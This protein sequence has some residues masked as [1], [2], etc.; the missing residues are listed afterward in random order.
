MISSTSGT[1][2]DLFRNCFSKS[3]AALIS[4]YLA[5]S[6]FIL[7]VDCNS[8]RTLNESNVPKEHING[9]EYL[10]NYYGTLE[11]QEMNSNNNYL[12]KD[13]REQNKR[14][15][16]TLDRNGSTNETGKTLDNYNSTL[17]PSIT[18][19][20]LD[21]FK[22]EYSFD[23]YQCLSE[24]KTLREYLQRISL[25]FY[26][27][28]KINKL[29]SEEL[30]H[31][32]NGL[33][34]EH[35]ET[36]SKTLK[37]NIDTGS[38]VFDENL[39]IIIYPGVFLN[40][41]HRTNTAWIE[42]LSEIAD[43][44]L[45]S[46]DLAQIIGEY[47]DDPIS[48]C[49]CT[50]VFEAQLNLGLSKSSLTNCIEKTHEIALALK[51]NPNA[52]F[53]LTQTA[54]NRP[55][56]K[57]IIPKSMGRKKNVSSWKES[58][59]EGREFSIDDMFDD[60]K[61]KLALTYNN[62]SEIIRQLNRELYRGHKTQDSSLEYTQIGGNIS[63]FDSRN[64][65]GK[66]CVYI[67]Y[68]QGN[69]G[70]C[71]AFVVSASIS[72]SNCI[73]KSELP[74]PLSPQQIIDC[75]TNYGNL[76][77]EGGFYS[78]GWS[79]LLEQNVPKNLICSWEEYPYIDAKGTCRGGICDGCLTITKYNVFTGLA[80]NGDDGWDFVTTI[81][82]KVG[83]ISVSINSNL[84]GLTSYSGGLYRAPKC[85]TFEELDHA[86]IIVGFGI[87]KKGEK[88]YVIQ[89]SWGPSWGINGF[90][91]VSANSCDMFW[92]PGII[93]QSSPH[94]LPGHCA[95]N[96]LLLAYPTDELDKELNSNASSSRV[97]KLDLKVQI[98]L[99]LFVV[100]CI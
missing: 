90:M 14:N 40:L 30:K 23:V 48:R 97:K 72:I 33:K 34:I 98:I 74:A 42:H 19:I 85:T 76:G 50:F 75:S 52:R 26:L 39:N 51:T 1:E 86:V 87:D 99:F 77:C 63:Y 21:S 92:Y 62:G 6:V 89:N 15:S 4:F 32:H 58:I 16:T 65:G 18:S 96:A 7:K 66:S 59:A 12:N 56:S 68:D 57:L 82:P 10:G 100:I 11:N 91:N 88:Y 46:L 9:H 84:P 28:S 79:Y 55:P 38:G 29:G 67:P 60:A 80:L 54:L 13:L 37:I 78:N 71:Y 83:S 70:G 25:V 44:K 41:I 24:H 95:G 27:S 93:R 43:L 20:F 22:F 81:L 8:L 49:I 53:E 69:C 5:F 47:D 61:R 64:V 35:D 36:I 3:K 73:Q 31:S 94:S 17:D 45:N 2:M